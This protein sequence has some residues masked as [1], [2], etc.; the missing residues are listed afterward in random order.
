MKPELF[1][2]GNLSADFFDEK[3]SCGAPISTVS[4][5]PYWA[6]STSGVSDDVNMLKDGDSA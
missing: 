5:V 3:L 6:I 4:Y 2:T 1:V